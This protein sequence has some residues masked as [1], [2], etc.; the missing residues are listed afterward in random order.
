VPNIYQ[1]INRNKRDTA[2]VMVVFIFVVSFIAWFVGEY[3]GEGSGAVFIGFALIF[4]GISSFVSYYN[5]DK[6]VLAISGAKE[7]NDADA[8]Q[9][10][11]L[12]ENI[13][14]ASGLPRPKIYMIDDTAMNAFATGRDPQHSVI[15]FTTGI[16]QNLDKRE[17]EGVVAHELSHSIDPC[18]IETDM[19]LLGNPYANAFKP[20]LGKF[21]LLKSLHLACCAYLSYCK[22]KHYNY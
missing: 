15:C 11:D 10:Y 12:V 5:S 18:A 6:I 19:A 3:Y 21:T 16:V 14:I 17:L 20:C 8:P 1:N 7:I 9:L 13:C 4:S 22:I 2:V